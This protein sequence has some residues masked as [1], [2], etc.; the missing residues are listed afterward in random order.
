MGSD[1]FRQILIRFF[2]LFELF[3][4]KQEHTLVFIR[5]KR[6]VTSE[7]SRSFCFTTVENAFFSFVREALLVSSFETLS[8]NSEI[9]FFAFFSSFAVNALSRSNCIIITFSFTSLVMC[10]S[11]RETADF[12]IVG[13]RFGA[14]GTTVSATIVFI[15]K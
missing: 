4:K 13:A 1:L 5:F 10:A 8:S 15:Y 3:G 12:F 14:T 9:V 2:S 11:A 6:R 7:T